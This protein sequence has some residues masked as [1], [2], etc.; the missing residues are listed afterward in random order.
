MN[1][2]LLGYDTKNV[3]SYVLGVMGNPCQTKMIVVPTVISYS[4]IFIVGTIGNVCTCVVIIRTRS[5]HTHTNFYLFSLAL[6]DLVVLIF[7]LPMELYGALDFAYPYQFPEWICKVRAYLIEFTSYASILVICSFTVERWFA[8]CYPI[9][10]KSSPKISRAYLTIIVMWIIS[11][12][13][14]IPIGYV[15]KINRLPLPEWAMGQNWTYK[16]SD[17]DETTKNTEFCAMDVE[18][19]ELQNRIIIFA[20][21]AFFMLPAILMTMMYTHIAIRIGFTDSLLVENNKART[22]STHTVIKMLV[23]VVISFFLCWLPFHIQRLLSL[24][25]NYHEGKVP[26]AVEASFLLVY[27][28]SGCCYYTNSAINPIL[29]NV[30]S[31]KYRKAFCSTILRKEAPIK[32]RL[33]SYTKKSGEPRSHMEISFDANRN[34]GQ[35]S[36]LL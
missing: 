15:V 21:V 12:I 11:S 2:E 23:S 29:Y 1:C 34:I 30:F 5:M 33:Q 13:A 31:E 36:R 6:S 20:F 10:S 27:Y 16:V 26:P 25:I 7:G 14:A 4:V 17:D 19:P 35:S 32:S 22:K 3:S 8:I 28:I 18:K 9:R 24:F